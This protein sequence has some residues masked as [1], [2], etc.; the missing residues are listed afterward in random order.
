MEFRHLGSSGLKVSAI[1]YGNWVTHGLQVEAER[2]AECV[3][4]ALAAG[5]TTFDTA[6]VYANTVAEEIL[7]QALKHERRESLEVFTK[8]YFPTGPRGHNDTGLSRKHIRESIDGSLTRLRMDYVDVYQ[9]HRYDYATPLEETCEALADVV[10]AGKALYIGVSEWTAE[11][12]REAHAL[13]RELHVPFVSNQPQ[14]NMLHRIIE[15]VVMPTCR[16]L[17]LGQVVFSPMAQ[18]ILT[19]KYQPGK[20]PPAGSRATDEK[21]GAR[22]IQRYVENEDLLKAVQK[23]APIAK[24]EGLTM[25]QLALAWVLHNDNVSCAI[26]G[27]SRPEQIAESAAAAGHTLSTESL[28]KIDCTL[29][30]FINQDPTEVGKAS[31]PERL[32]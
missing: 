14:Y 20:P 19:G 27:A 8:V 6:D 30:G 2:A 9:C 11:Q 16:E 12:I 21:G 31:P 1:A 29:K 28:R 26:A 32:A 7:G 4:A 13:F 24:S 23:L 3:R 25:G 18:G 5:I 17:G 15:P 10:R 22:F